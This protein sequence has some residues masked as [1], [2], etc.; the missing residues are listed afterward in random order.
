MIDVKFFENGGLITGFSVKGHSE[1]DEAGKDIVCS[2]V[3]SAAIMTANTITEIMNLKADISEKDGFLEFSLNQG[4][5]IKTQ[6]VLKGF[7][8]HIKNLAKEYKSYLS[9]NKEKY[10]D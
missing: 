10:N 3:S 7:R 9:V 5:A 6:D 8:F 2:A 1:Y 4:N